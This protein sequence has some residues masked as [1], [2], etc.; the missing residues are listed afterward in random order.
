MDKN[1]TEDLKKSCIDSW[2]WHSWASRLGS[3]PVDRIEHEDRS[4]SYEMDRAHVFKLENGKY[5][6]V[7]ESGCSC[8][9]SGS[10]LIDL[11]PT[12]QKALEAF[13]AWK[14]EK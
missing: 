13:A 4:E 10:A 5:A 6:L 1:I 7:T 11:Y 3:V 8:Y 12:E 14:S 2:E 9:E